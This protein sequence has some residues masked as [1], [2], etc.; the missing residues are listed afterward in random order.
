MIGFAL[1]IVNLPEVHRNHEHFVADNARM[2]E[3]SAAVAGKAALEFVK[4]YPGFKPRTGALQKAT[5][6]KVVRL[7]NGRL[8]TIDNAK[9]YAGTIDGGSRPHKIT[10]KNGKALMFMTGGKT[11]FRRS[12]NHP[13]TKPY[14]TFYRATFSAYRSMGQDLTRR[15]TA[16]SSRF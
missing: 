16:L 10:A 7:A 14:K 2:L 15:M 13:G 3:E 6:A 11:I 1:Q 8:L 5:T 9:P 4:R 12:V